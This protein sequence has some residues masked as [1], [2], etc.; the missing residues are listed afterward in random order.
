[1]PFILAVLL[2][3]ASV[4]PL[5]AQGATRRTAPPPSQTTRAT[6]SGQVRSEKTNGPLVFAVVELVGAGVRPLSAV[7][8]SNGIYLLRDVP[9][10]R[11]L[12]RATHIDHAANEIELLIVAERKHPVDF[13][14]TFRPLRLEPVNAEGMRGLPVV[15][16]T[17]AAREADLGQA[18]ARVLESSPGVAELG[19][20]EAARDV[21]GHEPVDP[22]DVLYVRGGSAD[23]KLVTLNGAP[24]YAPF[25]IGGLIHALDADI[26]RSA[27]LHVGGAPA[28]FDGGL[29]YIMDLETRAGSDRRLRGSVGVDMISGRALL[30][31]PVT[32]TASMLLSARTVHGVGT[33]SLMPGAFPY[34]Y[35]DALGRADLELAP[36]HTVTATG[37]WNSES[38]TLDSVGEFTQI[39]RWGNHA[40]S[41]RYRGTLSGTQLLATV[42]GGRFRTELPLGGIRPLITEGTAL[43]GRAALDLERPVLG[44]RLFWGVSWESIEFEHRAFAH[45]THRDSTVVKSGAGGVIAGGY[46]ETAYAPTDWLRLRAGMRADRFSG[47]PS[48]QLGPRVSA[49][50]ML[51]ERA[52]ISL[53]GGKYHQYVR[54]P[55]RSLVFLGNAVPDSGGQPRRLAVAEGTHLVLGLAQDF[56]EGISLGLEGYFKQF[57]GLR[58]GSSSR[59]AASGV[60]LWLRRNTG[61]VTGWLG[62]SLAWVWAVESDWIRPT[63]SFSGRH[64]ISAGVLGPLVGRGAFDVRVSYGAGLP[65]TAI[66][67]PEPAPLFSLLSS[68]PP[69][70]GGGDPASLPGEPREPYIRLDAQVSR[71]FDGSFRSFHFELMPYLKVINALNRRDAIFYHYN[72]DVGHAEPLADLP[73]VPIIGLEWKF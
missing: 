70:G 26:L 22:A 33:R 43:R 42:T 1:M 34:G 56:G 21:P 41:L 31:G 27:T 20:P 32:R 50:V 46:L 44:T 62:Y 12:L 36:G 51:T 8:D 72:R 35:G 11:R 38:V 39:A 57:E 6:V 14:L 68:S 15:S 60:D 4:A 52:S 3:A 19:L 9:V 7:T 53:S 71:T 16:D 66:P 59:T 18:R 65:Y 49:T 24:V 17:A 28:R 40:G 10:G 2:F 54:A 69:G 23:L 13:D 67:E 25:H 45:G 63:Q 55:E 73:I 48:I 5:S 29:S 64:L 47:V 58:T 61:A 37:F 30:E